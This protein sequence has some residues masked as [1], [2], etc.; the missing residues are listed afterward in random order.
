MRG[1]GSMLC[2][3]NFF[4]LNFKT[5]DVFYKITKTKKGTQ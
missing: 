5:I 2:I 3:V 1:F 4:L